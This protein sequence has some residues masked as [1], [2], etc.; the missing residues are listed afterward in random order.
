MIEA[1][2]ADHAEAYHCCDG[3]WQ[4]PAWTLRAQLPQVG[5]ADPIDAAR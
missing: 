5:V 3:H 1:T 2:Q 4:N